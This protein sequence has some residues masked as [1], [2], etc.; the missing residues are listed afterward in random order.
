MMNIL[1]E[2]LS[3]SYMNTNKT[4]KLVLRQRLNNVVMF[5]REIEGR[6]EFIKLYLQYGPYWYNCVKSEKPL[7]WVTNNEE[8]E[9]EN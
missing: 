4:R 1:R 5:D 2:F 9:E 6:A 8:D 3:R 7:W